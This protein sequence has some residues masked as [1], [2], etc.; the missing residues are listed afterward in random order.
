MRNLTSEMRNSNLR[1]YADAG[2]AVAVARRA[3][4]GTGA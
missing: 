4:I 2:K 3:A 1:K